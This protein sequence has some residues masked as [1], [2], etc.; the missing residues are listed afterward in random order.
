MGG[1]AVWDQMQTERWEAMV[2]VRDNKNV[3]D[4]SGVGTH[5]VEESMEK[6]TGP[7]GGDRGRRTRCHN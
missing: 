1:M 3:G 5:E 2:M 4:L 6:E 7:E